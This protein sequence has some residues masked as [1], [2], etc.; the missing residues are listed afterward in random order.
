MDDVLW[1]VRLGG[2]IRC[3]PVSFIS[4]DIELVQKETRNFFYFH[5]ENTRTT[6]ENTFCLFCSMIC[7]RKAGPDHRKIVKKEKTVIYEQ[8]TANPKSTVIT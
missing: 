3:L 7:Y 5:V 8:A 4:F 6:N 2:S 1:L